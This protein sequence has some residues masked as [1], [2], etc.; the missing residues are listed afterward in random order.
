M[1]A[2][3]LLGVIDA[4]AASGIRYMLVGSFS[5]NAYGVARATQDAD[6][7][8]DMQDQSIATLAKELGAQYRLDAQMSFETVT[9]T[10]KW[11]IYCVGSQFK[12]ELFLL[13]SDAH[14]AERFR[15]RREGQVYGRIVW[16]PTAEDVVITKLRWSKLGKRRK[17]VDDVGNVLAV[18]GDALDWP[19]IERWC[20]EHG[21]W[22]LLQEIRAAVP[23]L[24]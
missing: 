16:L 2:D 7:V 17:D 8:I 5:S 15:R 4:L 20:R 21:T 19:Y 22:D 13:G 10:S 12:I 3:L 14:D 24:P 1:T 18:Q 9:A 6:F 11:E 23:R